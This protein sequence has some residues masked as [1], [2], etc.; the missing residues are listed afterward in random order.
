[1]N[2]PLQITQTSVLR[3]VRKPASLGSLQ[4]L[5]R[6][7]FQLIGAV[8]IGIIVPA[9]IRGDFDVSKRPLGSAENTV[10]GTFMAV[11]IWFYF[12]LHVGRLVRRPLL[13]ILPGGDADRLSVLDEA[14]WQIAKCSD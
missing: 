12:V 5:A 6:N 11:L 9:L 10:I 14:D 2:F 8:L 4:F 7:R 13:L 3:A 1:M